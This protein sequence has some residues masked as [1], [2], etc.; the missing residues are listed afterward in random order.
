MKIILLLI[1]AARK[2]TF[3]KFFNHNKI[4]RNLFVKEFN[5]AFANSSWTLPSIVS[6]FSST[7]P[8]TSNPVS[9]KQRLHMINIMK[10]AGYYTIAINSGNAFL[11]LNSILTPFNEKIEPSYNSDKNIKLE[12]TLYKTVYNISG[13]YLTLRNILNLIYALKDF[14]KVTLQGEYPYEPFN[15]LKHKLDKIINQ[16]SRANAFIYAH[17]MDVH[18]EH[19]HCFKITSLKY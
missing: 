16:T 9:I 18:G 10:A 19:Y 5:R 14:Y 4:N 12:T 6:L 1:D 3:A 15:K 13:K 17:L 2:D 8:F 7:Y 11:N